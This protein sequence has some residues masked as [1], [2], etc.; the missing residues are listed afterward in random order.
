[1]CSPVWL[2][3][4]ISADKGGKQETGKEV[5]PSLVIRLTWGAD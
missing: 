2:N 4:L 5:L 3:A 1:M